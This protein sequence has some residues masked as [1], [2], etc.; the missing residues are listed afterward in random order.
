MP[1]GPLVAQPSYVPIRDTDLNTWSINFTTLITA[2][3]TLYGLLAADAVTI[4]NVVLP[5]NAAYAT[6]VNP[7]TRTPTSVNAKNTARS[8]MLAVVRPYSMQI[9][10]NAGVSDD[11]KIAL[12]LNVPSSARTPIPV[13]ATSPLCSIMAATPGGFTVRFQDPNS[14]STT[15]S[16]PFGA[17]NVQFNIGYGLVPVVDPALTALAVNVTTQPFFLPTDPAMAGKVATL[18]CRWVGRVAHFPGGIGYGPWS[19]GASATTPMAG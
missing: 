7:G 1:G 13:P 18:F 2:N 11:D 16:K 5:W 14:P 4:S 19:D 12:G 9:R 3:P 17:R 10:N 6:A 8:Q 15:R